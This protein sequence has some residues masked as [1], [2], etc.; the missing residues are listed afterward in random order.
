MLNWLSLKL[1]GGIYGVN[2]MVALISVGFF[3]AAI[4]RWRGDLS[5]ALLAAFPVFWMVVNMG[6]TRQAAAISIV[7]FAYTEI[8]KRNLKQYILLVIISKCIC[9]TLPHY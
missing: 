3:S 5:I 6:Y 7:T 8:E 4:K 1:G 2:L 9:Y